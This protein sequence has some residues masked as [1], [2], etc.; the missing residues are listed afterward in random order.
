VLVVEASTGALWKNV[1]YSRKPAL[2]SGESALLSTATKAPSPRSASFGGICPTWSLLGL[3]ESTALPQRAFQL[4]LVCVS[5]GVGAPEAN[6]PDQ[7]TFAR[8]ESKI[9]SKK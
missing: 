1:S 7:Q 6:L 3:P 4:C 9:G 2:L 5:S 8:F